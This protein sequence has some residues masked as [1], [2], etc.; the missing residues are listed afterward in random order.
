MQ[1]GANVGSFLG[2]KFRL[3]QADIVA[4]LAAGGGAGLATAF[5]APIAGVVFVLEEL[6]R[7]F[8]T[9]IAIAALG[10]SCCAI[11][12]ARILLASG[13]DFNVEALPHAG[14]GSGLLFFALGILAGLVGVVYNAAI[15]WGL[16]LASRIAWRAGYRAAIIGGAIGPMAWFLPGLVGGG[17][18]ITQRT[19]PGVEN[20]AGFRSAAWSALHR[21]LPPRPAQFWRPFRGIRHGRDGGI[22]CSASRH[23]RV[24]GPEQIVEYDEKVRLYGLAMH[25][26]R[27]RGGF[28]GGN[29][30][31]GH[32]PAKVSVNWV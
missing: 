15:L 26:G 14:I 20:H 29:R 17:D 2:E 23:F 25:S 1:I 19:L 13:P 5:N 21:W 18:A 6:I 3:N 7:R 12:G 4:L 28:S 11:A 30:C 16:R 31:S 24:R 10:A 22:F 32:Q 9:R 27:K 8:D